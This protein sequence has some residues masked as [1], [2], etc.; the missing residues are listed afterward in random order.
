MTPRLF[1]LAEKNID[2]TPDPGNV[3]IWGMELDGRAVLYWLEDGISQ[4]AVFDTAESAD[5]RFGR[6]FDLALYFP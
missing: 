5:E 4:F 6:I 2:G 1:G 3:Q